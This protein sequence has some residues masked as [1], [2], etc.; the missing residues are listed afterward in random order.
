M[1]VPTKAFWYTKFTYSRHFDYFSDS[2]DED[3]EIPV[4]LPQSSQNQSI[5][6]HNSKHRNHKTVHKEPYTKSNRHQNRTNNR[7]EIEIND[8]YSNDVLNGDDSQEDIH[9]DDSLEVLETNEDDCIAS[10]DN[11]VILASNFSPAEL[12]MIEKKTE[13]KSIPTKPRKISY[14]SS[15]KH[16]SKIIEEKEMLSSKKDTLKSSHPKLKHL[17]KQKDKSIELEEDVEIVDENISKEDRRPVINSKNDSRDKS[18][19]SN[20][21][22]NKSP[23]GNKTRDISLDS[24]KSRDK[25]PDRK[26]SRDKYPIS[27][28]RRDISSDRNRSRDKSPVSNRSRDIS[29]VSKRSRDISL[30]SKR[31][32]DKS[33]VSNRSRDISPV[34]NRSSD[35]SP[36]SNRSRDISPVSKRS[37]DISPVSNR[38]R[39]ISPISNRSRDISPVSN[40]SRDISPGSNR[41]RDI[42]P[43]SNRSRD[44][45][46]VI[47][48][49][50][51]TYRKNKSPEM[52]GKSRCIAQDKNR[53]SKLKDRS[54][55]NEIMQ[56]DTNVIRQNSSSSK[57]KVKE[58]IVKESQNIT[59]NLK[60]SKDIKSH[61]HGSNGK[62]LKTNDGENSTKPKSSNV[63]PVKNIK[64]SNDLQTR[65]SK[66][67]GVEKKSERSLDNK[68]IFASKSNTSL[69]ENSMDVEKVLD[70]EKEP[71]NSKSK[72]VTVPEINNLSNL[73]IKNKGKG[74]ET[75]HP[76][77][78]KF[79]SEKDAAEKS[80]TSELV[81]SNKSRLKDDGNDNELNKLDTS[82]G[83]EDSPRK[84]SPE[85]TSIEILN[86][87]VDKSSTSKDHMNTKEKG[88]KS[89][90]DDKE[91]PIN[92]VVEASLDK[93]ATEISVEEQMTEESA[94]MQTMD[95]YNDK[96]SNLDNDRD[97]SDKVDVVEKTGDDTSSVIISEVFHFD[98]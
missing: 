94:L 81:E 87:D 3:D 25:S 53:L 11:E 37:R 28:K 49:S 92:A 12:Q 95:K 23:V 76:I 55:S 27:K 4:E 13:N 44:I 46:P 39:D 64:I 56:A 2:N 67:K 75:R 71:V 88:S 77:E 21:I 15:D 98:L 24:K 73:D 18:P 45:S 50:I 79:S 5:N 69:K 52:I 68:K 74:L 57:L 6:N 80:R 36:V 20:K 90:F 66:E 60:K 8:L 16:N 83:K 10:D 84:E 31:S 35:I 72:N 33:P 86:S 82:K 29:P 89:D 1:L 58:T 93:R 14:E 30:V 54:D 17:N 42:S 32:R 19:V 48:K 43:V 47:N 26:K 97:E 59:E 78:N 51:S 62:E 9:L 96:K 40:R 65:Q 70:E 7:N 22:R 38:S 41:S 63:S 34:S 91:S 61:K 85:D